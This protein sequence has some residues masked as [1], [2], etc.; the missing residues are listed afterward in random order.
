MILI[1]DMSLL[2]GKDLNC[3]V[4]HSYVTDG[5]IKCKFMES[6]PCSAVV[7]SCYQECLL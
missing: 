4:T 2:V 3:D 6:A 1:F 5:V 7:L